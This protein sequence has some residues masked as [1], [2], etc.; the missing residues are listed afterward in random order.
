MDNRKC[1]G[2]INF[3]VN[4]TSIFSL[5]PW[6]NS[7]R[8]LH[9]AGYTV[10]VYQFA[11]ERIG[12]HPTALEDAYTL[13]EI[14]Y[15]IIAKYALFIIKTF[16]RSLRHVGLRRLSS[17][18]D[19]IDFLLRNYYYI[20]ACL[21]KNASGEN[22]VFIGG[23]PGSLVAAHYLATKKRGTLVYWS[24]ELYIEKNLDHFGARLLKKA[25]RRC[26]RDALCTVDFG[27]IRCQILREE[28]H[29]DPATM[30]SIPN[31]QVGPGK[32]ARNHFFNDIFNIPKDKVL[33][34]H[35]G[36]LFGPWYHMEDIFSS[37]AEWPENYILIIHTHKRPYPL[38][39]FSIPDEYLNRKVFLSE[40]PVAFDQLDTLY[41]SC[42]IGI[43]LQ[44]PIDRGVKDNLYYSDLSIGKMFHHL[45]VGVPII[46]RDLPG[47][48]ELIAGTRAGVC[49][50]GASDI[51]PAIRKILEHHEGYK[52]NALKLH[53]EFRFELHHNKLLER[54]DSLSTE[55]QTVMERH[56][57]PIEPKAEEP[58]D[59][60]S[61]ADAAP[62]SAPA[63][64]DG[65]GQG[66][67]GVLE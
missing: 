2:V 25:E 55:K 39:G 9:E 62:A 4:Y 60:A 45:K 1:K 48:Q 54:L 53:E 42:D 65:A 29:L 59:A 66:R 6:R 58:T 13:V 49:V 11:D 5:T 21:L 18:G 63:P 64:D 32:I 38:C 3:F 61:I 27:E 24:L 7:I 19:G 22:E 15:P 31:S 28:N 56:G 8:L 40:E 50:E 37:I 33:V 35:A 52:I 36:G 34:L 12:T 17:I 47:F 57:L 26:N 67:R 46:I 30:I 44:G 20:A 43:I 10:R 16:F 41:S 23:D 51:L 14:H